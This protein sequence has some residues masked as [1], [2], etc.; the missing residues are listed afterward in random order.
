MPNMIG[1]MLRRHRTLPS[2]GDPVHNPSSDR[3]V[4]SPESPGSLSLS[5]SFAPSERGSPSTPAGPRS[6]VKSTKTYASGSRSFLFE[7]PAADNVVGS[8][9]PLSSMYVVDDAAYTE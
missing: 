1:R 5:T 6:P 4:K 9:L 7:L 8:G 3:A 2:T